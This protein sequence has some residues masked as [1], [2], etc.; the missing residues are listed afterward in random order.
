MVPVVRQQILVFLAVV[1]RTSVVNRNH[2]NKKFQSRDYK[3]V[4][5]TRAETLALA[6]TTYTVSSVDLGDHAA[7]NAGVN[8]DSLL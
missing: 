1:I 5:P 8:G 7:A 6:A 3:L 4:S 2:A